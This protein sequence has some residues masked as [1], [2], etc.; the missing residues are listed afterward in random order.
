MSIIF[1]HIFSKHL[2]IRSGQSA[3]IEYY[4]SS[5]IDKPYLRLIYT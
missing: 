3:H 4:T 2:L 1:Q 5:R